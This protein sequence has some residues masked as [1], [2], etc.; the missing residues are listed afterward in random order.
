VCGTTAYP[1]SRLGALPRHRR[2]GRRLPPGGHH[3]HRRASS[4]PGCIPRPSTTAH[5]TTTCTHKQLYG[6]RGGLILIG[7][8]FQ[9]TGPDGKRTLPSWCRRRS[10]PFFQGAPNQSAIAAKARGF[11]YVASPEFQKVGDAH[12]GALERARRRLHEE[13]PTA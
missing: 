4:R 12:R 9:K 10:S 6:G 2:L 7:K 8:D 1:R 5:F 3:A 13:G 11:A